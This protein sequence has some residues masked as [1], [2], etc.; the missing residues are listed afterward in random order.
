MQEA[1]SATQEA[2]ARQ[3][4]DAIAQ[5]AQEDF[6]QIARALVASDNASL[7]GATTPPRLS[8]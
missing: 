2:E 4:A 6:L 8:G 1:L 3:L 7:F 5:A